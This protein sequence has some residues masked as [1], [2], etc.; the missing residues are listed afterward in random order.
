M[1]PAGYMAKHVQKPKG[2]HADSVVDVYSVSSCV[3]EDFADYIQYW[4]HNGY[5]LFDS[6]EIIRALAREHAIQLEGTSL[7]YY[8]AHEMEFDGKAWSP[9]EAEP[10]F[11]TNVIPPHEK[12]VLEGFDVVT[13]HAKNAPEHSPLSCNGLAKEIRTNQHCLLESFSQ[14]YDRLSGGA[15]DNA[16]PGPYRIF[17][18]YSVAWPESREQAARRLKTGFESSAGD[19]SPARPAYPPSTGSCISPP[20]QRRR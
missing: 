10:S 19:Q 17:A 15:F 8:E 11:P 13:F 4:K 14:A 9:Y 12:R 7:F 5:W 1:I 20:G 2:F 3:N 6:P 16:E 18:V